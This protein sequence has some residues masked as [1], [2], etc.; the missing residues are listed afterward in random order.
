METAYLEGTLKRYLARLAAREPVPGGGSA[1]ALCSALGAAL[2]SMTANF[3]VGKKRFAAV[4]SEVRDILTRTEEIRGETAFLVE[5]D[6]RVY[7]QYRE[8]AAREK[9]DPGRTAAIREAAAAGNELLFKVA[10]LS[11]EILQLADPLLRKGNPYLLSDVACA[12]VFARA[13]AEAA[14]MN[15]LINLSGLPEHEKQATLKK[16]EELRGQTDDLAARL[17]DEARVKLA[18]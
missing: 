2:L 18:G 1:A 11:L 13:A 17:T 5:E 3:T 15:I 9:D 16:L 4:E 10:G 7:L 6:S 8:A 12:A 14:A